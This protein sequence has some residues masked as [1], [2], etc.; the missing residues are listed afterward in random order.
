MEHES[1][2]PQRNL[3]VAPDLGVVSVN[4]CYYGSQGY[5]EIN[6]VEFL[7]EGVEVSGDL[8]KE[9]EEWIFQSLPDGWEAEEGGHGEVAIDVV[10][11]TAHFVHGQY[12]VHTDWET[13]E[14]AGEDER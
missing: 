9:L 5:P 4:M 10:A 6:H 3:R 13:F 11:E 7:P 1:E 12:A 14:I 8:G 2:Q